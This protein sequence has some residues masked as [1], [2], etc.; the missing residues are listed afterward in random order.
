MHQRSIAPGGRARRALLAVMA[1]V[2]TATLVAGCVTVS[3]EAP[4][5]EPSAPV[6][7][8][9]ARSTDPSPVVVEGHVRGVDVEAKVG[10][11]VVDGDLAV[12]RVEVE[13]TGGDEAVMA[14]FVFANRALTQEDSFDGVRLVDLE[15]GVV[16]EA[17]RTPDGVALA[18]LGEEYMLSPGREPVVGHVAFDAPTTATTSVLVPAVGLVEGVPV[19][20][21]ADADGL[22]VPVEELAPGGL[23]DVVA[24][25]AYLET[26]STTAGDA[27]RTRDAHDVVSV[28]VDS[29]VL[30]DVDS[31]V[32]GPDAGEALDAVV[33]QLALAA[34]GDLVVVGHTDDQGEEAANQE[35]SERRARAVADRLAEIADLGRFDVQVEGRGESEPVT[36]EAT[37]EAR[38]LNRRVTVEFTPAADAAT[39]EATSTDGLVA[40]EGPTVEGLGGAVVLHGDGVGG[41]QRLHVE[42][43]EVRRAGGYLVGELAVRNDGPEQASFVSVLGSVRDGRGDLGL[44][45]LGASNVTLLDGGVRVYP[46]DYLVDQ[47]FYELQARNVLADASVGSLASGTTS[48]VSVVWPDL[49]SDTVVV[50]VPEGSTA[51]TDGSTPVRFV[52]VPVS[53]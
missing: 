7:A 13:A 32:I 16:R 19:V 4:V 30:F 18:S 37:D 15:T 8:A 2:T 28:V 20:E 51:V 24:S 46:V 31:D 5:G 29:D 6:D 11:V 39:V 21:A 40:A 44:G 45:L 9:P 33:A 1:G 42:L 10:P 34:D 43:V 49:G 22:T 26:F 41:I 35:L 14:G 53:G 48:T 17:A 12:L 52:D 36:T 38:A 3:P 23:A 47:D 25:S 50:D 27:V